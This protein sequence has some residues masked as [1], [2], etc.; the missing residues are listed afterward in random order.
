MGRKSVMFC[1][2]GFLL[3]ATLLS[4]GAFLNGNVLADDAVDSVVI[5]VPAACTFSNTTTGEDYTFSI[6]PGNYDTVGDTSF[7]VICNDSNGFSVYAVGYSNDEYGNT[8]M[9][10]GVAANPNIQTGTSIQGSTSAWAMKLTPVSGTYAP[11]ISD[12][13]DNTEDFTD[14]H[15]VPSTFTK[16]ATFSSLTDATI[17]SSFQSAYRVYVSPSQAPDTYVGKVRYTV[18]HPESEVPETPA[19]PQACEGGKICYFP[20]ASSGVEYDMGNQSI[21]SSDTSAMLWVNN[22]KRTGYGFAGWTDKYN[23]VLGANDVNGDGTGTNAGYHIYGPNETIEFTAGQYATSGLSLYAVWVPSAGSLQNWTCPNSSTMPVGTVTALTDQRDN[24]TYAVAKL[25]DGKCWMIENLRLDHT[26]SD[27]T[28]GNLAQGY[29]GQFAGLAKPETATFSN[30]TTANSIYYSGTQSGTA[31]INIGNS[32]SPAYRIPRFR[33]DNTNSDV[34]ANPNTTTDTMTG[35][36]QNVYGY[37]NYYTWAAVKANTNY[38]ATIA[39]SNAANTSICPK[40]WRLPQG[41]NKANESTNEFWQLVVTSVNNGVNP[42]NYGSSSYPS[43]RGNEEAGLVDKKLRSFPYNIVFSGDTEFSSVY[44]RGDFAC[45]WSATA[46]SYYG[47]YS[48]YIS[49]TYVYPGDYEHTRYY[50]TSARCVTGN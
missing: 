11:T 16:V 38:Y 35:V 47:T 6:T 15:A 40:G 36:K 28:T 2:T 34:T 32:D 29:G 1:C 41:G 10:S 18:V 25:A 14:F 9:V 39:D 42:A 31:S 22:F 43:Y 26:N 19:Q 27:N 23:W 44:N 13:T 45:Y 30:T 49:D 7:Q 37:G 33:N 3:L 48:F 17:G 4:V 46:S 21:S 12:G 50:A 5:T 8:D 20:N 24:N